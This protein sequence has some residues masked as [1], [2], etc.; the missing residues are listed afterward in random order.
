MTTTQRAAMIAGAATLLAAAVA[1]PFVVRGSGGH[2]P[3]APS[4][5]TAPSAGVP[6]GALTGDV[7]GDGTADVVTL[8][9]H[10]LLRVRL[11][12]GTASTHFLQDRPRLEGLADVGGRGLAVIVSNA[13]TGTKRDW[14]AWAVRGGRLLALHRHRQG[15]ASS[16]SWVAGRRFYAGALDPLQHGEA[17]VAVVSRRWSLRH[18]VL[19]GRPAGVRCWDRGSGATP[20]RCGP[21]QDWTFDVGPHDHLPALLPSVRPAWADRSSTSFGG[22]T[23]EVRNLDADVDPEAAP[24]DVARTSRG[25]TDTARV[26]V[27]WAPILFRSPVRLD[28]GESGVLLSQEGGD[29]DTWRVYVDRGGRVLQLPTRGPVRLGGGFVKVHAGQSVLYSWLTP[30]GRLFTRFGTGH[31]GRYHVYAW[32]PTSGSLVAHDLG[33]V[34]LDETL[35]TY[36]TCS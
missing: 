31:A 2:A 25:V 20:R 14:T 22:V 10:D 29:S 9:H 12:S 19:V 16:I 27:G 4:A 3:S 6:A 13:G 23:W 33:I 8:T 35:D 32:Q 11:G 5:P 15:H 24:Y 1:T 7:D 17:R 30:Q 34:C 21:G 18:G 36:G 26:P 28:Q